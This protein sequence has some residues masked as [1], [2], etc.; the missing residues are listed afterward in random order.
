[1]DSVGAGTERH[2]LSLAWV[3]Q[4]GSL[5]KFHSPL[6]SGDG[7]LSTFLELE[8]LFIGITGKELLWKAL[9]AADGDD[10]RLQELIARAERQRA[11]V[12]RHRLEAARAALTQ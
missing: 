6:S 11:E 2:K 3:M 4:K 12:E 7:P 5:L 9:A 10:P 8:A 1:M